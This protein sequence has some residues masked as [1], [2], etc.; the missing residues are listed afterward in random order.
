MKTIIAAAINLAIAST[1]GQ[2]QPL[3]NDAALLRSL[4]AKVQKDIEV[5]RTSCKASYDQEADQSKVTSGDQGLIE[6]T[7]GSKPAVM[8]DDIE[9]CGG[10]QKGVNC[11]N[12]GT[13]T[14]E[15]PS[16]GDAPTGCTRNCNGRDAPA[17]PLPRWLGQRQ[18]GAPTRHQLC[19][20]GHRSRSKFRPDGCRLH[21]PL[22]TL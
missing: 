10:C 18:S 13:R 16:T 6:F 2:S 8:I 20:A 14:V 22:I 11:S 7:L 4:P 9:I 19:C 1:V 15:V 5:M 12:R 3:L 17:P 21:R